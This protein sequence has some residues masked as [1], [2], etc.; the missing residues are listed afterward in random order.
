MIL[1]QGSRL[2][3]I[4]VTIGVAAALLMRKVVAQLL[5]GVQ[6]TDL[7]TFTLVPM[8]LVIVALVA[9]VVP[10]W[11]ATRVDPSMAMRAE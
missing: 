4:G 7:L 3:V 10:A 9:S 8:T 5:Y 11:R 2:A 1:A 6:P